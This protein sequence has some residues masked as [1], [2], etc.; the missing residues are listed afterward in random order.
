MFGLDGVPDKPFFPYNYIRAENMDV[1]HVGLPPADAYDPDRM[2]SGGARRVP[3]LVCGGTT[4]STQPTVRATPGAAPLT[5]LTI[6]RICD[7]PG[8]R[9]RQSGRRSVG[10]GGAVPGRLHHCRA[11]AGHL[12]ANNICPGDLMVHTPEGGFLRGTTRLRRLAPLLRAAGRLRPQWRGRLRTARWSIG[13]ACVEDDGYRTGRVALPPGAAAPARHRVQ[14]VLF[15][16]LPQLLSEA[17]TVVGRWPD[18]GSVVCPDPA[19]CLGAGAAPRLHGARGVGVRVPALAA[20]PADC[21]RRLY[22]EVCR[23]VP[24][25]MDLRRDALFG[26]RVEPFALHY[27]CTEREE[28]DALDIVSLYPYVMKYR[29]FPVGLPGCSVQSSLTVCGCR[30]QVRSKIPSAA[31]S[32][33]ACCRPGPPS[34]RA[35]R[36]VALPDAH[37][38]ADLSTVRRVRRVGQRG[39]EGAAPARTVPRCRHR[40]AQR[41]WTHAYTDVELNA[42]LQLGYSV[43]ALYEVWH[44]ERWASL[45]M[46]NSLFAGYVDTMLRLKVEAS[47]WPA[48]CQ[49]AEQRTRFVARYA[50][51]EGIRLEAGRVQPNPG[52]RAR[53]ERDDVC[54]TSSAREF[55]ELLGDP[56]QDVVDFVHLNEQLDRC[57]VRRRWPFVSAPDTN[58][59]AVACF[60]TAHAR[61]HLHGRLEEVRLAGGRMLYCDTDSVYFGDAFGQLKREWPGRRIVQFF[62]AG[63]KNYGFRH[64]VRR[65]RRGRACGAQGARTGAHLHRQPTAPFERMRQLVLNFFGRMPDAEQRVAVPCTRSCARSVPRCSRAAAPSCTS[66]CTPKGWSWRLTTGRLAAA[67]GMAYFTRPFGWYD[68]DDADRDDADEEE[69]AEDGEQSDESDTDD[70]DDIDF[71][72]HG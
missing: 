51:Q 19:A 44:Y 40:A 31:S 54:Y 39:Q 42:A 15:P 18:R 33:A 2:R 48:D 57:V 41:A 47:G 29:A 28:I 59:L 46:G 71:L 49:T 55:H 56:R 58:N 16:W 17:P 32:T 70:D 7:A 20:S 10:R 24:G 66:P 36:P 21:V 5:V 38:S 64:R 69:E 25:P 43:L 27:T 72:V 35:P 4:A 53:A 30:G 45:E 3:A 60:V 52:L 1:A 61:L 6:V 50:D 65:A 22:I 63:P 62:S 13:E 8:L 9:F 67:L 26:G 11:G 37:W 34:W 23:A 68:D 12:P 14:R